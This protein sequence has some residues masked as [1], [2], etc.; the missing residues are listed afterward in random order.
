ML[1]VFRQARP[2]RYGGLVATEA[3]LSGRISAFVRWVVRTPW[4]L[5]ALSML[6]A[7]I[8]GGLFV[9]GFLRC[10]LPPQDRSQLQDL[11]PVNLAIF[12]S[13]VISLFLTG[14]VFNLRLMLPVFR[15]QRRDNLLADDDPGATALARSRALRMPFYRTLTSMAAWCIGGVVFI[16]A[17]WSVAKYAAPVVA[18]ATAL[19][20]AA[21]AIIGYLQSERVLRP[22]AVA[23]LRSGVPENVKAPGVILRQMLSWMLSTAVPLLA[24][25]LAVV[26]D[27]ISLLHAT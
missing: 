8:I 24:I 16:I 9:L 10:G 19:G 5:F 18:V 3:A 26:A 1:I 17:S 21:T 11:P 4:P 12:I 27:K 20:A 13:V 15:W 25:V 14:I 2:A 23:A 22:V 7:D 6:Q